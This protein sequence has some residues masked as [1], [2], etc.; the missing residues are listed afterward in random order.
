[1]LSYVKERFLKDPEKIK[2]FLEIYG[3]ANI[4]IK[5][6]YMSFGRDNKAESSSKSIVIYLENNKNLIVHDHPHGLVCDIFNFIIKQRHVDF[7]EVFQTAKKV[8]EIE[9]IY[10][11]EKPYQ[12]FGGFYKKI[13]N[14][15]TNTEVK[16]YDDCI[17][18][19]YTPCG[20]RR[21]LIDGISLRTQ[22][23]FNIRY[24]VEDQSIIIP[25]YSEIGQLMGVK[26]RINSEPE[27]VGQKYYY[28][29]P[30]SCSMTL[31]NYAKSYAFLESADLI[32]VVE[33]E[34]GV[35]QAMTFGY[36]N[37]VALGSGSI[38][39]KQVQLLLQ[40]NPKKIV[41]LHDVGYPLKSI[42][43]NID[44][45]KGYTRMKEIS[46]GYWDY[47]EK[48]Y[49]DKISATDMGKEQLDYILLNEIKYIDQNLGNKN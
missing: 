31:Y 7:K 18:D 46:I 20:N 39:K 9:N 42:M 25:I 15:N 37:F 1:M 22:R 27:E 35:M 48:S 40:L 41:F 21:F 11:E 45:V 16:E 14:R 33:A 34:K 17:L 23:F 32:Y 10:I 29:V 49:K 3:Y 47:F 19:K 2:H 12:A 43:R 38:S 30:C 26:C 36:R 5:R 28:D 4:S 6:N 8:L 13:K 44:M 24:S